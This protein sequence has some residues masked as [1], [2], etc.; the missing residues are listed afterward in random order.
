MRRMVT[1]ID[2]L[3]E[4]LRGRRASLPPGSYSAELF[5]DP[6]RLQRQIMEE[7]FETCLELGRAHVDAERVASEAADL[8]FHLLVGLV[9]CDVPFDSVLEELG[10]RRT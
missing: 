5:R 6:E 2:E 9:R 8:F 7:A 4:V 1:G 3:E 10:R